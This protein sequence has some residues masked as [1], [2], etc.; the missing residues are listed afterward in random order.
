MLAESTPKPRNASRE[1]PGTGQELRFWRYGPT[2][3]GRPPCFAGFVAQLRR[4][5]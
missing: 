1:P 5:K 3:R 4:A 2:C